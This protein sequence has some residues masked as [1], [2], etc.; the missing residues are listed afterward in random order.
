MSRVRILAAAAV[1]AAL[2]IGLA[3]ADSLSE[4]ESA[5]DKGKSG[6][7]ELQSVDPS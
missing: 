3:Y 1:I 4:A 5:V 6:Y 7:Q 2:A